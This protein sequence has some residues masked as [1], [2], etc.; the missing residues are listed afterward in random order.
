[1]SIAEQMPK[2]A[3]NSAAESPRTVLPLPW[4]IW[5]WTQ[6]RKVVVLVIGVTL[7][8]LGIAGLILPVLPG[9][10]LI[11]VGLVVLATEFAWARWVLK[12]AKE[13]VT[14]LMDTAK[15]QFGTN[16]NRHNSE[17]NVAPQTPGL[18]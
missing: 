5:F 6:A 15:Q 18:E 3:A 2:S 10:A 17:K 7:L 16:A 8:L 12:H 11:F 13:H 9:W 1:M 4:A 14:R